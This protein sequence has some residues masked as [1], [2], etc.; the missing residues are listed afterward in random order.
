M[1]YLIL[2]FLLSSTAVLWSQHN[3]R[4]Q[5]LSVKNPQLTLDSLSIYPN[6][7]EIYCNDILLPRSAYQLNY[8]SG[9]IE[10]FEACR[11]DSI[12]VNYRVLPLRLHREYKRRDTSILYTREKGDREKFLIKSRDVYTDI[13]GTSGIRK[14]GSISRGISFGNNQDLSVNSTLN[15]ELSGDITPNLKLLAS[16]SDENLP[17]QPEGNTNQLQEFDRV[18]IQIYND[19]LKLVAGDFWL[20]KPPGYFMTYKKRAQGLLASYTWKNQRT[21]GRWSVQGSGAL[22]K[23][24]FARQIINGVEGNQGPYRLVG[25]ENEPF[26]IILSGTERV[27]IDGRL[28]ERGQEYDYVINYNTAEVIFTAKN[29][30]TKDVRIVVEFQYSDQNYAR[31]LFQAGT[32]YK[33]KNF[34]FWM[35]SYSEQDAKNQTIQQE[36]SSSQKSLLRT[37]GDSLHLARTNSIDSVGFLENQ[38]MYKLVSQSG[39]DSVLVFSIDPDSAWYRASFVYVGPNAGNYVLDTPNA[40]GKVFRWVPPL[41]GEP[42]G[43]YAP[44]RILITPKQKQMVSAGVRYR[45]G[46]FWELESELAYTKNDLNTFSRLDAK[47]DQGVSNHTK[48]SSRLPLGANRD[49]N[50]LWFW[51]NS[52]E[53]EYL[54][55][56]FSPIEQY[57]AVEFDRDWNTRGKNFSGQQLSLSMD[58]RLERKQFGQFGAGASSYGIG[59]DYQ[60]YKTGLYGNWDRKGFH[61]R[62]NGS[63]LNSQSGESLENFFLRHKV[64]L[65]QRVGKVKLGFKDDFERNVFEAKQLI[66]GSSY[67]FYDHEYFIA[68]ADSS[69]IDYKVYYRER[70]DR[71]PD[72]IALQRAAKSRNGGFSMTYNPDI[73]KR[74]N[75][76]LNYRELEIQNAQ[77]IKQTPENTLL[78]RL[79]YN[80]RAWKGALTWNLFYEVG[81]G[82]ELKKEFLYLQVND[83]QGI[84]TWIDYNGDGVKDLNEFE[85]AQY[86]DQA[87]Y[88]RV[89]TPSNE[90]VNTFSN[91]FNQGFFLKPERI[92]SQRTGV[93][94]A[95]SYFSDQMRV[96]INRKTDSF[97]TNEVL[98]P[99]SGEVRDTSLLSSGASVRN[100]I[101][102]N[103][104]SS[105]FACD[106]TIQRNQSKVLLASGFDAR[107][108]RFQEWNIR[109][110]IQKKYSLEASVQHGNKLVQADYTTGRNY[111]I[112]YTFVKPSFIIQ[113]SSSFRLS[114]D[115]RYHEKKNVAGETAF[116]N[117]FGTKMKLNRVKKGS[118][119]ANASMIV[120]KYSGESGSALGFEML[121]SLKTG[122]NFTW[123][124]SYQRSISKNLQISIQYA[125]RKSEGSKTI[126]SGGM[127]VRAF[128]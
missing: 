7:V 96:R 62:W 29:L 69:I 14:N 27:Y 121:E 23:G 110:N 36:L 83:G 39:Y 104:T 50:A 117:E 3:W 72:S 128:F 74:L 22:S 125:G 68:N 47:D 40:L 45:I 92:W 85:V 31:S 80:Q 32:S 54:S 24:K 108:Q 4:S 99:F 75:L 35:N 102:F 127:E 73:K 87:S 116:I 124:A 65:S 25:N 43:N 114:F 9:A 112:R 86:V 94:K 44:A 82:L 42:Q 81:S 63:L 90:Y 21:E 49:S 2:I 107:E 77:L 61:A 126:H 12:L 120:I 78:G 66:E 111:D 33:T 59:T 38:N 18:F 17:I 103:R 51:K 11:S 119:Q 95:L 26:I 41:N 93:L 118:F 15:L 106:Y 122:N 100:T 34:E 91:E 70:I 30:I 76:V 55:A 28:L 6:S 56:S 52:L 101:F 115:G 10:F 71:R 5:K 109:W 84:Y 113:P 97:E 67:L 53:L 46:E 37:V 20:S 123:N 89:F 64:M 19:Q 79:D 16:V 57:R 1:R 13:F 105:I 98:N 58:S 88:I 48:I 60:G 8:S